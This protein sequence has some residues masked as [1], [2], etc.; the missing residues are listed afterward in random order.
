MKRA[1]SFLL[2]AIAVAI[3]IRVLWWA[4]EP[5]IPALIVLL[6]LVVVFGTVLYRRTRW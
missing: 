3:G 6:G 5:V 2:L 4:V 1:R